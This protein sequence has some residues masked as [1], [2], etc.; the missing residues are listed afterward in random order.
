MSGNAYESKFTGQQIE[1]VL[2]YFYQSDVNAALLALPSLESNVNKLKTDMQELSNRLS[3]GEIAGNFSNYLSLS[4]GTMT[5]AATIK[6]AKAG[7]GY[8]NAKDSALLQLTS[9]EGTYRP[10]FSIASKKDNDGL[11]TES[12]SCG[13]T[14]NDTLS[15]R[16]LKGSTST[17]MFYGTSSGVLMGAAWNDYAEFRQSKELEPGRVVCEC[18]DG[19]LVLANERLQPGAEI[20]SDT[21]GFAIGKTDMCQTPIAVSGR[22]LAYPLE[23][24]ETYIAGDAVCAGPNGTVSKM[25]R[26]EIITYP[27]RIIGTVSE[28][29]TYTE[30]GKHN[31]KVNGRIWIR[32]K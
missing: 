4:G 21:F 31:I 23:D 10:I 24:I 13:V 30:W 17:E 28:I 11:I 20:I 6:S 25:T 12:F 1:K 2:D 9:V 32:I 16:F 7:Q 3:S 22:V 8:N 5:N 15:F 18:G 26:E 14:N 19:M 27:D 29:P